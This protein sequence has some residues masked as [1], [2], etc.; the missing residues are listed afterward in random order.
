MATKH[1]RALFI[2]RRDL[3]V[4]D[5][6]ALNEA[7]VSSAEV[8]PSFIFDPV[9]VGSTNEYRS[10]RHV[11][12]MVESLED[13]A[14]Q[15]KNVD[16][17]LHTFTGKPD[18]VVSALITDA[19][20]DAVYVNSDYTPYARKRDEAVRT[21][22]EKHAIPFFSHHDLLLSGDP[23]LVKTGMKK[24][25]TVFTPYW[26]RA[27]TIDVPKPVAL[28][29]GTFIS[30]LT[31]R[32]YHTTLHSFMPSKLSEPSAE[33]GG[34][35]VTRKV[36][37]DITD[38]TTYAATHNTLSAETTRLSAHNKFGTVSIREVYHAM[39]AALGYQSPL[40]RQLYWRDFYVAIVYFFPHVIG[41]SFDKKHEI[42]YGD[43]DPVA[44]K[45]WQQGITGIPIVDAG[46]RELLHT[47]Y[48]HN[49]AR[50]IVGSFLTKDLHEAWWHGEKHFAQHLVDYD[51][52]LNNGNWQ[53]VGGTG[54]DPTPY[55]RI[56]N[57]WL[58][59]KKFDPQAEYIKK[60]VP[61]LRDVPAAQIHAA[62]TKPLPDSLGYPQPMIDH[63]T[64]MRKVR[65]LYAPKVEGSTM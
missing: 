7:M 25:F 63:T 44:F 14:G 57:P 9:Q 29:K 34:R 21:V 40:I 32:D 46:M 56:F 31:K 60:W 37:K 26:R 55:F 20:I 12:F 64:E 36:L 4:Q 52:S 1:Q 38:F 30:K 49:R 15:Y 18:D 50:L 65:A 62:A 22:C 48:M 16:G 13:L 43:H 8:L 42:L 47:G 3:R 41:N 24:P 59:G 35:A 11:A 17:I 6:T 28:K 33:K 61:E 5:N 2:H 27:A 58:Q 19:K 53:W 54:V 23:E 45:K 39:G 51:I 10:D